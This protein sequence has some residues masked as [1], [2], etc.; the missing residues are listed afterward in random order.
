[1]TC[2]N[3]MLN[4]PT[5]QTERTETSSLY[6]TQRGKM[7]SHANCTSAT[8]DGSTQMGASDGVD[9]R[10]IGLGS[11]NENENANAHHHGPSVQRQ[12]GADHSQDHDDGQTVQ[13][14]AACS[15]P[16]D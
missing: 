16:S 13:A 2:L 3:S 10:Q 14:T 6:K 1:M 9:P 8:C 7:T 15:D 11:A 12:I 4:M 5:V